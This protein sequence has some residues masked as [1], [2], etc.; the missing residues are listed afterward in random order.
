MILGALLFDAGKALAR[1]GGGESFGGGGGGDI[2][3]G[4]DDGAGAIAYLLIRLAFAYPVIG[5]PLLFLFIGYMVM[6]HGAERSRRIAPMPGN[7]SASRLR[8]RTI[9][10]DDLKRRDPGFSRVVLSDFLH[11]L[12]VR[13]QYLQSEGD[14]ESIRPY[15]GQ[16]AWDHLVARKRLLESRGHRIEE[17]LV[18]SMTMQNLAVDPSGVQRL[19]VVFDYNFGLRMSAQAP[20]LHYVARDSWLLERGSEARSPDPQGARDLGCPGCGA[21]VDVSEA[22]TCAHCGLIVDPGRFSWGVVTISTLFKQPRS[23]YNVS[24][25]G[26]VEEGTH[27]PDVV[28]PDLEE[29]RLRF[30]EHH[31]GF[32]WEKLERHA[33][34]IF[35]RL[36]EAWS[37]KSWK[38]ARP[39]ESDALFHT[40]RFFLVN[41]QSKGLVNR[42]DRPEI[43]RTRI[44]RV[45][46]DRYY[47]A[48][49]IRVHARGL[50]YT[51][52]RDGRVA[53]GSKSRPRE[54][55]EYWTFI[56]SAGF[57]PKDRKEQDAEHCPNCGAPLTISM[58]G[59]CEYCGSV[60][61]TGAFGWVL[62]AIEQDEAYTGA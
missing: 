47:D 38:E 60:I 14:P 37:Q 16:R 57:D 44:V 28:A 25:R 41:L 15:V 17:V 62:T 53:A 34:S 59:E 21:A 50:E 33:R 23:D 20:P 36:Q 3:G 5:I 7:T 61:T 18:G 13:Y 4:G 58:A 29:S 49:T 10:W 27:L 46:S 30:E 42:L 9:D 24:L 52:Q 45:E 43:L 54:F 56:R 1:V 35:M 40:H 55:S 19:T 12:F 39:F 26:G 51:V 48:V 31:P 22:N 8:S 11:R 2:G 6:Q 32:D